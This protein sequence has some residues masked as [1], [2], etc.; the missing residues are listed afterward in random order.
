M[1]SLSLIIAA[2]LVT[3][4][5]AVS[6]IPRSAPGGSRLSKDGL[7]LQLGAGILAL[8]SVVLAVNIQLGA[9]G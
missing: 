7:L 2:A 6:L 9:F 4:F 8:A 3:S 5:S 1:L